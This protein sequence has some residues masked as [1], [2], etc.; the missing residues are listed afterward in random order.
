MAVLTE[1]R[2]FGI[3]EKLLRK[4]PHSHKRF[5]VLLGRHGTGL[6]TKYLDRPTLGVVHLLTSSTA[7]QYEEATPPLTVSWDV[8]DERIRV[9][10]EKLKDRLSTEG[11]VPELEKENAR[12]R[13]YV[14]HHLPHKRSLNVALL[15]I[16]FFSGV[17]TVQLFAGVTL[18]SPLLGWL[19]LAFSGITAFFSLLAGLEWK[20]WK[21]KDD[22]THP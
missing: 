22:L 1:P 21:S 8:S 17:L 12:L 15:F 10:A 2:T 19:G 16:M 13:D 20:N 3:A 7:D 18:I 6:G 11:R 9:A 4:R 5:V 14:E